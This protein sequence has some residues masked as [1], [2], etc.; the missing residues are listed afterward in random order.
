MFKCHNKTIYI[1]NALKYNQS[2]NKDTMIFGFFFMP[3]FSPFFWST[4][5]YCNLHPPKRYQLFNNCVFLF[6]LQALNGFLMMATQ[7]GKLLYISDNA[8]EYLGH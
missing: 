8:A 7:T 1:T 4:M 5:Q 3:L 6:S 2:A